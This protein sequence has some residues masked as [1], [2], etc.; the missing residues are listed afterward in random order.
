MSIHYIAIEIQT[1]V[2]E[3][4]TR[5]KDEPY[6]KIYRDFASEIYKLEDKLNGER[7]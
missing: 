1:H 3:V 7:I 2:K 4:E 5:N 6:E